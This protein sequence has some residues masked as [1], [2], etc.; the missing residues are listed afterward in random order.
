MAVR[1]KYAGIPVEKVTI[2]DNITQAIKIPSAAALERLTFLVLY[3]P[4][5]RSKSYQINYRGGR[6]RQVIRVCHLYPD[7][8]NLYGDRGNI[9]AFQQR[10]KWRDLPVQV[11]SIN[12][13]ERLISKI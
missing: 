8:L 7:L 4:L 6:R 2:D 3:R 12:L 5:D 9:I 1:L 13:G 10:C 11:D